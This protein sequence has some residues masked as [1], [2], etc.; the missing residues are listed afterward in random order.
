MTVPY[1]IQHVRIYIFVGS[2]T[3]GQRGS[4]GSDVDVVAGLRLAVSSKAGFFQYSRR[5]E[6]ENIPGFRLAEASSIS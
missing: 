6:K 1:G 4:S 3:V 5:V 2:R